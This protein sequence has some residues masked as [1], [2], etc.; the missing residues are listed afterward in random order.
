[1]SEIRIPLS[2][3]DYGSEEENAVLR[4]L[5]SKWVSMGPETK[6]FE[7]EFAALTGTRHAQ[8]VANG[9]AA[10]HLAFLALGLQPGD[11]VIQPAVN[12]VATANMSK[13]VGATPIFGDILSAE[14]PTLDPIAVERLVTSRTKAVVVMH[15]GGHPCRM[16]EISAL[17]TKNNLALVEDACHAVGAEFIDAQTRPPHGLRAGNLGDIACFSFFSNKNI[18]VGEG[19]MVT[20]DRDDLAEKIRLLRSHGMSTLTWDRHRGHA[21]TY[22][23]L[24]NGYNYRTDD[25]HSALGRAQLAK[26]VRNNQRRRECLALY[27]QELSPLEERGWV[28]PFKRKLEIADQTRGQNM[29]SLHAAHLMTVVAP[30]AETRW[31]CAEA[32]KTAGIQTSLHYPLVQ[33]FSAFFIEN[34]SDGFPRARQFCETVITLP[35]HPNLQANEV[36]FVCEQL[37]TAAAQY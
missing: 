15:F 19:G 25:I 1:M 29:Q 28:I 22:D 14:E 16:A 23:V 31:R 26:L 27:F 10:L 37:L 33:N 7:E 3:L 35:L 8:A 34:Q 20:T 11:E 12:F 30:N 36:S 32:L 5:K 21:A 4:V 17:C 6:A 2:D 24:A 13:A 18:A 9:T